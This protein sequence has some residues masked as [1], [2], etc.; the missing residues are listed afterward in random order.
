MSR[1]MLITS[2]LKY[3]GLFGLLSLIFDAPVWKH[4]WLFWF[5]GLLEII[6][7]PHVFLQ[8]LFQLLFMPYIIIT[9]SFRLPDV[10]TYQP[11]VIYSLPFKGKWTIVN[12]G[13]D[14]KT[15]HSW[16][17]LSQRYAYD[18]LILD[19]N[20]QSYT[21][22]K[23]VLQNYYCYGREVLAPA[24][25]VVIDYKDG[26]KD[27]QII[28]SGATD[29]WIKDI[30]GNYILLKHAEKEYSLIAHLMPGSI[31]VKIGQYVRRGKCIALCGN[32]GNSSEPHIHFQIQD[33]ESFFTSAGLPVRFKNIE[34]ELAA[35][36]K[37]FD[38]RGYV[39]GREFDGAV[40]WRGLSVWNKQV[41]EEN[42][43]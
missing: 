12:G 22:D 40:V 25:G 17:V 14:K 24:D 39:E 11:K 7:S 28:G 41:V 36:Y 30:R 2:K 13:P 19:E 34:A 26:L 21:G 37:K 23:T 33:G 1:F 38:S 32:S 27:S 4:M 31:R 29:P 9:H 3:L 6:I 5:F 15:S 16:N 35:N 20:G 8:S 42:T 18:F 10:N 43:D